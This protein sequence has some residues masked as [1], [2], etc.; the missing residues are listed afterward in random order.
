MYLIKT[1]RYALG[2]SIREAARSIGVAENTLINAE[3]GRNIRPASCKKICAWYN[4]DA[5]PEYED[6]I[7]EANMIKQA[8]AI[9]L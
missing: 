3:R 6:A 9:V 4:V 8:A 1:A 7:R 5:M 2:M